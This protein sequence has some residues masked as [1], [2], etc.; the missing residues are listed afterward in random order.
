MHV[1]FLTLYLAAHQK[2]L[3]DSWPFDTSDEQYA[4]FLHQNE[5]L[6]S[7]LS[8]LLLENASH[9]EVKTGMFTKWTEQI[10]DNASRMYEL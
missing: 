7:V 8:A 9:I 3:G 1:N 6:C 4:L 2:F 10:E 5:E